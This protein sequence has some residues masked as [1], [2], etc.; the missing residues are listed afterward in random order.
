M[1]ARSGA[2]KFVGQ[3][4]AAVVHLTHRQQPPAQILRKPRGGLSHQLRPAHRVAR[5]RAVLVQERRQPVPRG[6]F[7]GLDQ[8]RAL[9]AEFPVGEIGQRQGV[10]PRRGAQPLGRGADRRLGSL[11]PRLEV[12]RVG[13]VRPT[14]AGDEF[15]LRSCKAT[16]GCAEKVMPRRPA[17]AARWVFDAAAEG[18]R[19][20]V[21]KDGPGPRLG[22]EAFE[23][24]FRRAATDDQPGADGL[25]VFRQRPEARAQKLLAV[26]AG[27]V[28]CSASR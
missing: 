8:P 23:F 24:A 12:R 5:R 26:R 13:A 10:D 18:V 1:C 7:P 28:V 4:A 11:G 16:S 6:T 19:V 3:R 15:V 2:S 20:A 27:P 14:R 25:Q 9:A 17:R 22:G 21:A